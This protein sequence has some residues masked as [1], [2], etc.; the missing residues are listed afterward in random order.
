MEYVIYYILLK[1][2]CFVENGRDWL[3]R[4]YWLFFGLEINLLY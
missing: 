3:E 1:L 2:L 4:G